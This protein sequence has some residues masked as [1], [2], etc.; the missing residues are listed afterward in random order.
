M[1]EKV[2]VPFWNQACQE[3]SRQLLLPTVTGS[4]DL[5]LTCSNV[6]SNETLENSW[7][8][9][10]LNTHQNL[11]VPVI[12]SQFC[13]SSLVDCPELGATRQRLIRLY[14]TKNQKKTFKHWHD[15]SRWVFNWTIDFIRSCRNWTPHWM[16]IKKYATQ[17]LPEWTKSVPFQIKGNSIKEA[18]AAFWAGKGRPKFRTRKSTTQ[19][20]YIPKSAISDKGIYPRKSGKGLVIKEDL[21]AELCDSRL[22]RRNG[23]WYLGACYKDETPQEARTKQPETVALDPGIRSFISFYSPHCSGNIGRDTSEKMFKYFIAL[24]N[25]YSRIA[26]SRNT[27]KKRS[28]KKAAMRLRERINNLVTELHYKTATFLCNNFSTIILPTFET[29][30]MAKK[31]ARK[32]RSKTVRVMMGLSFYTFRKRLEWIAL[33]KGCCVVM[34]T[35]EYTSRTHPQT[36]V[37]NRKLG[38]AKTIKLT[39]GSRACRDIAGAYNFMLKTLVVDTPTFD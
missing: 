10:E 15:V 39:D 25:L 6:L 26:K 5:D 34:N 21:P 35:E 12:Y 23:S 8:L 24:D 32:I 29:Q 3:L 22:I 7:F 16:E 33:K 31:T 20:C 4:E 1:Q 18:C 14:P 9:S 37:V 36:G 30:K 17:F 2:Y 28:L 13:M 38:S 27:K 19:S 11:N